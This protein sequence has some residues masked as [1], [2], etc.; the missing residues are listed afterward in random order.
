MRPGDTVAVVSPS[1]P[2]NAVLLRRGVRRLES[3]GLKVVVGEHVLDRQELDYL[4]GADAARAADLQ[5]AW[6]DPAVSGVFCCRGGYGAG[7]L[8]DLL[9]WDAMR[10]AGR[11]SGPKVLLGSSD[12]TA[13]HNAFAIE[14]GV[15]TLHGPMAACDVIAGDE[16]GPEPITWESLRA[17]LFGPPLTVT[18]DRV[19]APGRAE[20]VLRGGNLSLIASMCGTRWQPSFDGAIA[21]LEDIGEEPYR[22]D[23]MLTQLLQAGVFDGVRGIALGSWVKCGDPYPVLADRLRSLGV[24]IVAGLPVGHGSPQYSVWLGALGAIDTESCSL[25][26]AMRN[27]EQAR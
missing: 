13:L 25:T 7:R 22:I 8:L 23:R 15:P 18:G 5:A 14:L 6:C 1:G 10:E 11:L 12:I 19:L 24:P 9:D 27:E 17:A 2:P 26:G 16:S 21:F 4:A 20:G 3:L